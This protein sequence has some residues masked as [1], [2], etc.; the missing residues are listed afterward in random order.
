MAVR[1]LHCSNSLENYNLCIEHRVAGFTKRVAEK[2]DLVYFAVKIGRTTYCGAR[3]K[4]DEITDYK[5]W[6]ESDL[7]TQCFKI[8]DL[9]F[10]EPFE[11]KILSEIGGKYW[12]LKYVQSSKTI[13]DLAVI[14]LLNEKFQSLIQGSFHYFNNNDS[15]DTVKLEETNSSDE[16]TDE[17][18]ND[19]DVGEALSEVPDARIRIMGTFQTVK[20]V[21]ESNKFRGLETLVNEN[22]YHLF[23]QYPEDR[24]VLITD[25]R[26]FMTAGVENQGENVAGIRGIPDAL[27]IV[28]NK[29]DRIPL[30]INLIE[31]ECYGEGRV[32]SI[33]KFNYLNGHIIPQLMRFAS[34]FSIV[35]DRQIRE[36]TIQMWT[37]KVIDYIYSTKEFNEKFTSWINKISPNIPEQRIALEI[38]KH[39]LAAFQ[40]NLRILLV[41]DELT[42]EQRETIKNIIKSFKLESGNG[43]EF[44]NYIVR[45]EQKINLID[46]ESDYALSVQ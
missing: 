14:T 13:S 5:P 3:A 6:E 29:D 41:I 45:L 10:C 27:L 4:L 20:F 36:Q 8:V 22:F 17:E 32:R 1:I 37:E 33:D 31:Y 18:I 21:N 11:L 23:P 28:F 2:G 30:Q 15:T 40:Y 38:Q 25:N 34:A 24:T 7:Y 9:E 42:D 39:L 44:L 26:R 35:T 16:E 19:T 43:I 46:E 12:V